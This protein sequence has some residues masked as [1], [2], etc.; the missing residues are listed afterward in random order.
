MLLYLKE[1]IER[2]NKSYKKLHINPFRKCLKTIVIFS[3][4][5]FGI[6]YGIF[7]VLPK[8]M[9]A[10]KKP[11]PKD[12]AFRAQKKVGRHEVMKYLKEENGA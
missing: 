3:K 12:K 11:D 8:Y 2:R 10:V 1:D 9:C 7:T 4:K 5:I 6:V